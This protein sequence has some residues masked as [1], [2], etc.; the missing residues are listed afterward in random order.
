ML[1]VAV[2]CF[3]MAQAPSAQG[4]GFTDPGATW[5][6]ALKSWWH[7]CCCGDSSSALTL[8]NCCP[9]Q[10]GLNFLVFSCPSCCD[11]QRHHQRGVSEDTWQQVLEFSNTVRADLSN[12]D[13]L[14]MCLEFRVLWF[15]VFEPETLNSK[16][17]VCSS[18]AFVRDCLDCAGPRA[19][20]H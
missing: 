15:W 4:L 13:S 20:N 17:A 10:V 3:L 6:Q 9:S 18:G 5:Q 19:C 8:L 7:S 16:A 11:L 14:G 12:Y 2:V 1:C